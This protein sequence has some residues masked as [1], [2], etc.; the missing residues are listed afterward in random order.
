MLIVD[1]KQET[2]GLFEYIMSKIS[3]KE[4]LY[5]NCLYLQYKGQYCLKK[6]PKVISILMGYNIL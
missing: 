4:T 5:F 3:N 1:L 6:M 2:A